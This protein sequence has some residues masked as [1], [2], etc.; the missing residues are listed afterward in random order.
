MNKES[1]PN[2]YT[3]CDDTPRYQRIANILHRLIRRSDSDSNE[4]FF[5]GATKVIGTP[6][7]GPQPSSIQAIDKIRLDA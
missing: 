6:M 5:N 3:E 1:C 4:K 2:S 7:D